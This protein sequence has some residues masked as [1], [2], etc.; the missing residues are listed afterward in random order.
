ME[1]RLRRPCLAGEALA[2]VYIQE[3]AA[4]TLPL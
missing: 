2:S 4:K 1:H 3:D